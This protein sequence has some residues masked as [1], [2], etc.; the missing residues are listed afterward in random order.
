MANLG[1]LEADTIKQVKIK[2]TMRKEDLRNMWMY[3]DD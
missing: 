2:E 3:K 1:I